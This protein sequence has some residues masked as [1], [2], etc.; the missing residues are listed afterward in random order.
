MDKK[1]KAKKMML[2]ALSDEMGED[3]RAGY[4]EGMKDKMMS[5]KVMADSKKGLEKGLSKAQEIMKK[6]M[7]ME[8]EY[9]FE[10]EYPKKKKKKDEEDEE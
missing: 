6:K 5:V 10:D 3:M 7:K 4:G 8:D 2:K 9:D 1:C